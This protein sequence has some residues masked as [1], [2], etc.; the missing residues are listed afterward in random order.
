MIGFQYHRCLSLLE[1]IILGVAMAM[2]FPPSVKE[3]ALVRSRRCCCVCQE[4][5]GLHIAV[6]HMVPESEGGPDTLENAIVLCHRCHDEASRYNVRQP[7]GNK[8]SPQ[9]LRRLRDEWWN[10]CD[11]NPA[12]PLPKYPVSVSPGSITLF[13]RGRRHA[14]KSTM[15][16]KRCTIRF[17]SRLPSI[18][19][20]FSLSTLELSW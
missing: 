12:V 14:S 16:R 3:E 15:K 19:P 9:E 7:L 8:Y 10:W 6:H 17:G 5:A 4:F 20:T 1:C 13:T 11:K 2:P 18:Y